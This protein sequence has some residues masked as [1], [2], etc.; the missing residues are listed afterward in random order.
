MHTFSTLLCVIDPTVDAQPA[1]ERAAWLGSRTGARLELLIHYYDEYL[2]GTRFFGPAALEQARQDVLERQQRRLE[3]LAEPLRK[4]GLTVRTTVTWGHPLHEGIVRHASAINADIVF[5]DTHHH[6]AVSRVLFTNTDWNLIRTCASPLWLVKPVPLRDEPIFIAA[7]DPMNANDKPAALDDRILMMGKLLC[8]AVGGQ[9]HAF[10]SYDQRVAV[11]SATANAYIPVSLPLDEIAKEMR[12]QHEGRF[13]ELTEFHGIDAPRTHLVS[14]LAH[15]EL[16]A[17][18]TKLDASV[19]IMGAVAR[20]RLQRVF[21]GATAE[22]T[23]EHLPCDLLVIKPD[24]FHAA[25]EPMAGTRPDAS[26]GGS[27]RR[28]DDDAVAARAEAPAPAR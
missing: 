10:H 17:L 8:S 13:R 1:L 5:K 25:I 20:N 24:W 4:S 11:S 9:V 12:E 15:E 16:P 26:P 3:E 18:A 28:P 6:S 7:I 21:I 23:L 22:R 27:P 2:A 19:V 14:G